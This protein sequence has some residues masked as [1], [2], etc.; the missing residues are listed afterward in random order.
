MDWKFQ[1]MNFYRKFAESY[2]A[3]IRMKSRKLFLDR[4]PEDGGF[5]EL[6]CSNISEKRFPMFAND[7]L[8]Q[9]SLREN[10]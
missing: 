1:R 5:D 7:R 4:C 2:T 3:S 10:F 9:S 6:L 8:Y